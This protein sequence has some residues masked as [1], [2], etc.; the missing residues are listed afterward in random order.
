M[1][2]VYFY[3]SSKPYTIAVVKTIVFLSAK[4]DIHERS[5]F[6][7]VMHCT[8]RQSGVYAGSVS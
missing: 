3:F 1:T 6:F 4:I 2:E 5:F 8:A 7:K